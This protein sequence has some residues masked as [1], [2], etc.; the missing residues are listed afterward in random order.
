MD[1]MDEKEEGVIVRDGPGEG[2]NV[3]LD[4]SAANTSRVGGRAPVLLDKVE[5]EDPSVRTGAGLAF[6]GAVVFQRSAKESD[7]ERC[8]RLGL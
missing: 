2:D 5:E 1:G 7:I 8:R 4:A 6:E 3:P